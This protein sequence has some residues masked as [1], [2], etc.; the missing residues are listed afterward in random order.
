MIK[1]DTILINIHGSGMTA[2]ALGAND[3]ITRIWDNAY[4]PDYPPVLSADG[5]RIYRVG[6]DR[7]YGIYTENGCT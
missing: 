2:Y 6:S 5:E 1:N 7:V 4:A 3:T